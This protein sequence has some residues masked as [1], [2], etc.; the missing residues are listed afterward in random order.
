MPTL[1]SDLIDAIPVAGR[2]DVIS[3]ES[4]NSRRDAIVAIVTELGGAVESR[5]VTLTFAPTFLEVSDPL[6]GGQLPKWAINIGLAQSFGGNP[7]V[8]GWLPLQLPDGSQIQQLRVVFG[9]T[10]PLNSQMDVTL[11]RQ[12]IPGEIS[13]LSLATLSVSSI[14][15][16]AIEGNAP[17][18]LDPGVRLPA[19]VPPPDIVNNDKYKYFVRAHLSELPRGGEPPVTVTIFAIR[20]DCSLG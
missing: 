15:R 7:A 16:D 20:V 5:N 3:P 17:F 10:K 9:G 1:L 11:Q 8:T 2:G 14:D 13:A 18:S 4:H 19:G 6:T 12:H